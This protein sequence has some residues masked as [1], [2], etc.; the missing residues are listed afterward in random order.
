[1]K[2]LSEKEEDIHLKKGQQLEE[3]V[4]SVDY[5][6]WV[7]DKPDDVMVL[8]YRSSFSK[9]SECPNC[10]FRTYYHANSKVLRSATYSHDRRRSAQLR[11]PQL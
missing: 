5:D 3:E 4:G 9:Y 8:A 7:S 2:K 6:V 11:L 10:G 1:M